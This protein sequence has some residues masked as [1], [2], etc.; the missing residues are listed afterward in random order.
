M[1]ADPNPHRLRQALRQ[2]DPAAHEPGLAADEARAMR[3]AM[4]A[5]A[6][7]PRRRAVWVPLAA[8]GV[9]ALLAVIL[10]VAFGPW[11]R[12][13]VPGSPVRMAAVPTPAAAPPVPAPETVRISRPARRHSSRVLRPARTPEASPNPPNPLD[14]PA[15]LTASLPVREIQFSTPGGTRVIWTLSPKDAR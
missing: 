7:A 8:A 13:T 6:P 3:R 9:A 10:A 14:G 1:N 5:A 2:G 15:S 12:P 4:L 11:H